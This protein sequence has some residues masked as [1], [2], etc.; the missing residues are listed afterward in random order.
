MSGTLSKYV[1]KVIK[2]VLYMPPTEGAICSSIIKEELEKDKP[3]MIARF[4]SVEIKAVLYPK[5]TQILKTVIKN[6]VFNTMRIN[7][8]FF[9]SN[10][11]TI[12]HFSE[13]MYE[14][15]KLLDIL[16]CWRIEERFLQKHFPS[17]K[18]VEL[19]ALEPYLQEDPWSVVLEG[20]KVLVIHP[21]N[22]T[23][24]NQY[25]VNRENLFI[26]KRVLPHFN[27]L[28]TIKAVQTAGGSDSIFSDW[29]AALDFMKSEID[30]KDFDIAIIGCGAYGFPLAAHVKRM[31]KKAVHLGGPT[32]MLFGIKGKRWVDNGDFATIINDYFVL[33]SD[34]D[35]IKNATKVEDGCYW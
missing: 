11:K 34:E 10:E 4:G 12:R 23:I 17:A 19:S 29:F 1:H 32:Q 21:F 18:R 26:D 16:G 27:S 25:H 35:K 13:L 22:D 6:R 30:K 8:G 9:P 20:K 31:G 15:M 33:P 7:A 24:E 3:S 14:D 28:E 5:A 2:D